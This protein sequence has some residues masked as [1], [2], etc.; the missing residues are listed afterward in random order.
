[1]KQKLLHIWHTKR[2]QALLSV[3]AFILIAGVVQYALGLSY[4]M[5]MLPVILAVIAAT[6]IITWPLQPKKKLYLSITV[7]AIG[8]ISELIGV[9]TGII[10]GEYKY[11]TLM[12]WEIAGTPLLIAIAWLI[13]TLAAWNI[14]KLGGFGSFATIVLAASITVL[15]DLLL[16]QFATAYG[17]WTWSN[18]IIPIKNYATWFAVSAIIF[19]IFAKFN[20]QKQVSLYAVGI[21][22]LLLLYFWVML[23]LY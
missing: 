6:M 19:S 1:M 21:M 10:F 3:T 18:S 12:G 9:N 4:V 22:P 20:T 5:T 7:M 15:F 11:G 13:V 16:E 14:A 8:F 23:L 2:E 17:L